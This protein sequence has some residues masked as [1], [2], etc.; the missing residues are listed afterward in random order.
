MFYFQSKSSEQVWKS[1]LV[2]RITYTIHWVQIPRV[3]CTGSTFCSSFCS[4]LVCN[5]Y[6]GII[7]FLWHKVLWC[8]NREIC[9]GI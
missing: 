8:S 1:L 3:C 5:E 6:C 7:Y 4:V 9:V 2:L